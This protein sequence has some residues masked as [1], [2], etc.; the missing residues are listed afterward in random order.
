M[1]LRE[2]ERGDNKCLEVWKTGKKG[3]RKYGRDNKGRGE[4]YNDEI[5]FK[6]NG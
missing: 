6:R 4:I 5:Y 3:G 1:N 2:S